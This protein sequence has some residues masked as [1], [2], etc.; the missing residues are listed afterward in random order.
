MNE[1]PGPGGPVAGGETASIARAAVEDALRAGGLERDDP[2]ARVH[3]AASLLAAL[4]DVLGE[5]VR[6]AN[7]EGLSWADIGR[8]TGITK[9][10]A[11]ARFSAARA[12]GR[13]G[14]PR[15]AGRGPAPAAPVDRS[16]ARHIAAAAPR[17][18][19]TIAPSDAVTRRLKASEIVARDV[20]HH[21][22]TQ[23]LSPGDGLP[24]EAA[25][26]SLYGVS[27]ESLREGLRL[28]EVQGLITI[29]RGP[30]G[31]PVVGTVDPANLGRICTLYFHLAGATYDEL[32]KAWVLCEAILAEHAAR[33]PDSAA[34]AAA[35]APYLAQ[36]AHEAPAELEQF[37]HTHTR[38]HAAVAALADN[39]V[40]ELI[41]Q[42]TGKVV[43]RHAA[44]TEDPRE[45]R[46]MIADDHLKLA[47]AIA[48]GH[49]NRAAAIA[50][51]HSA[52]LARYCRDHM[53]GRAHDYIE[54]E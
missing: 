10:A 3:A 29:R 48:A 51:E 37:V 39:R 8:L 33:N 15:P 23:G 34:R 46:D 52:V 22:V 20:V 4:D 16:P 11:H 28:L 19:L 6:D 27:R 14:L 18:C 9:Q 26:L 25:M 17:G 31:G 41:L 54:W 49:G 13:H 30:R 5:T 35:M 32:F 12:P 38:F 53:G 40:L 42:T 24:G 2:A 36:S 45:L 44:V 1:V 50:E 7:E 47:K 21:I 43:S